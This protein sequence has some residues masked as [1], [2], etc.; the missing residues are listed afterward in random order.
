MAT[1]IDFP[2]PRCHVYEGERCRTLTNGTDR[3]T[4]HDARR[5]KAGER[6]ER[7]EATRKQIDARDAGARHFTVAGALANLRNVERC[8]P[9]DGFGEDDQRDLAAAI[10]AL[11]RIDERRKARAHEKSRAREYASRLEWSKERDVDEGGGFGG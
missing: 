11:G 9:V 8:R 6:V 10:E 1:P 5:R 7:P 2:C 3:T 4:P